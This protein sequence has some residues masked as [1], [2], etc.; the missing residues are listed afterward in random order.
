MTQGAGVPLCWLSFASAPWRI[1]NIASAFSLM[2]INANESDTHE[3]VRAAQV[4]QPAQ[5]R[6]TT[7]LTVF[8]HWPKHLILFLKDPPMLRHLV[9]KMHSLLRFY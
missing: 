1:E 6:V 2:G 5:H 4:R 9:E 8:G 3:E 7:L